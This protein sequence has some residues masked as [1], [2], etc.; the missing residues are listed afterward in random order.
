MAPKEDVEEFAANAPLSI[1]RY[2]PLRWEDGDMAVDAAV[3]LLLQVRCGGLLNLEQK[4]GKD[5]GG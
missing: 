4:H 5:S 2:T 3:A 1:V